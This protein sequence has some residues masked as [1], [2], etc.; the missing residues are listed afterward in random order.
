MDVHFC[1]FL[2]LCSRKKPEN[3]SVRTLCSQNPEG[4]SLRLQFSFLSNSWVDPPVYPRPMSPLSPCITSADQHAPHCWWWLSHLGGYKSTLRISFS[5]ELLL[6]R[7]LL[8]FTGFCTPRRCFQLDHFKTRRIQIQKRAVYILKVPNNLPI[9]MVSL[10]TLL[11][12]Y[13]QLLKALSM[14][15]DICPGI[16]FQ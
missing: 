2:T 9:W 3:M 12:E 15:I 1:S 6:V 10:R 5:S 13:V 4:N 11:E 8:A 7:W 16:H 14:Y